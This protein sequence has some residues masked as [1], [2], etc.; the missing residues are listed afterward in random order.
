M[1]VK[2]VLAMIGCPLLLKNRDTCEDIIRP[3]LRNAIVCLA[4]V[5]RETKEVPCI[6]KPGP[7]ATS[8]LRRLPKKIY[9]RPRRSNMIGKQRN[10]NSTTKQDRK[11]NPNEIKKLYRM[12]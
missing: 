8:R 9:D 4:M 6:P 5:L 11:K 3:Q 12:A 2:H 7:Q 1:I 10:K